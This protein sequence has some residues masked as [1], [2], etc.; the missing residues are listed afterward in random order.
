MGIFDKKKHA[1]SGF[2]VRANVD[3]SDSVINRV[4]ELGMAIV[5]LRSELNKVSTELSARMAQV[6]ALQQGLD[7]ANGRVAILEGVIAN[8][9]NSVMLT[10]MPEKSV[11]VTQAEPDTNW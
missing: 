3:G 5:A 9:Y 6:D 4:Q 8:T 7:M 10:D 1:D 11:P 2:K